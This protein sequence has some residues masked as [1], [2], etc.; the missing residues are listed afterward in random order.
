MLTKVRFETME[1]DMNGFIYIGLALRSNITKIA[2][3]IRRD[4]AAYVLQC[5]EGLLEIDNLMAVSNACY[6]ENIVHFVM[7]RYRIESCG[8]QELFVDLPP[9]EEMHDTLSWA[10]HVVDDPERLRRYVWKHGIQLLSNVEGSNRVDV[11]IEDNDYEQDSYEDPHPKE[12]VYLARFYGVRCINQYF[13]DAFGAYPVEA[14]ISS[15]NP[16][17]AFNSEDIE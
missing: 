8:L 12:R 9:P 3:T 14:I 10:A 13:L 1:A 16:G 2:F 17:Y 11:I 6:A 7:R 5:F 4:P 15:L